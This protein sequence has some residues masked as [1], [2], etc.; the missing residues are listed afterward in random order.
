MIDKIHIIEQIIRLRFSQL[1]VNEHYKKGEFKIP[2]HLALGHESLAVAVDSSM[3]KKDSLFSTHR[4]IH[5]NL[6]RIDTL[7]EE[8]DE[9]FL[10][11]TG[12]RKWSSGLNEF[13]EPK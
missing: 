10:K 13:G 11:E 6:C 8:L 2:I 5:F 9:Y 12:Y 3:E 7:K 4:N 1:I